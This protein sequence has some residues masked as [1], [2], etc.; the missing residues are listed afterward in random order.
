MTRKEM[1][2]TISKQANCSKRLVRKKLFWI[3]AR[4]KREH[5]EILFNQ[6]F[7]NK[8]TDWKDFDELYNVWVK[9]DRKGVSPWNVTNRFEVVYFQT[10]C[11]VLF[12]VNL[13]DENE[14]W[15]TLGDCGVRL[16]NY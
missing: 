7:L 5:K 8:S 6:V 4:F 9:N 15:E 14:I 1:I 12:T 11:N 10:G 16:Y 2:E 13:F 3:S